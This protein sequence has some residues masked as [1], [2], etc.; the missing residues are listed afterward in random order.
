MY[1]V[2]CKSCKSYP[3]SYSIQYSYDRSLRVLLSFS[4]TYK[5]SN[6]TL[7]KQIFTLRLN[8]K[9]LPYEVVANNSVSYTL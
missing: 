8:G 2:G 1:P 6:P 5:S 3:F 9:N 4:R 7:F